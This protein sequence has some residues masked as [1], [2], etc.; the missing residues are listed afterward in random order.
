MKLLCVT[1]KFRD[2]IC[3]GTGTVPYT[4]QKL[5]TAKG[6]YVSLQL[7]HITRC[8]NYFPEQSCSL[9]LI[10]WIFTKEEPEAQGGLIIWLTSYISGME[11]HAHRFQSQYIFFYHTLLSLSNQGRD[12]C[13]SEKTIHFLARSPEKCWLGVDA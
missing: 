6:C 9:R 1:D 10:T 5:H 12:A 7:S 8:E 11:T 2:H 13:L 4:Q 3:E